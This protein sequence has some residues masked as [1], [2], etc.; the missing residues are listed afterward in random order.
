MNEIADRP[1]YEC[2]LP[3]F[4][5]F[6]PGESEA[7]Y[8]LPPLKINDWGRFHIYAEMIEAGVY[9]EESL[10]LESDILISRESDQKRRSK[11][12]V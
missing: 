9:D 11:Q 2:G 5:D 1:E 3:R 6:L 7:V 10:V 12:Y 4:E 8:P